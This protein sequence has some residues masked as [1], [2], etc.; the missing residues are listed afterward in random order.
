MPEQGTVA[1]KPA[2]AEPVDSVKEP[3][4]HAHPSAEPE[5]VP[6]SS[7]GIAKEGPPSF[8]Q[9]MIPPTPT[10]PAAPGEPAVT[11]GAPVPAE[12]VEPTEPVEPAEPLEPVEPVEPVKDTAAEPP[13]GT[14]L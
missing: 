13:I 7:K 6:S 4:N 3:V 1:N 10:E 5:Q 11:E 2:I 9:P 14:S 12:P 8:V